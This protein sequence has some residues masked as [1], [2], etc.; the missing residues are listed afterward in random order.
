MKHPAFSLKNPNRVRSLVGAFAAGNPLRF[1]DASGVGYRLVGE[2]VR[3]LDAINPQTAA[4]IVA[5]FETWK[6]YDEK[7][8]KLMRAELT[9]VTK[10]NDLS[11]NLFELINK[12][13][14]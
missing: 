6:R 2:V 13:L 1:H 14:G 3:A 9:E 5:V 10:R 8:Q 11:A 7:R 12:M 4:R